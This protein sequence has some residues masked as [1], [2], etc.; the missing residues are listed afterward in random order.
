[1]RKDNGK[2]CLKMFKITLQ[3]NIYTEVLSF[4]DEKLIPICP[5]NQT[6]HQKLIFLGAFFFL[7]YYQLYSHHTHT[8]YIHGNPT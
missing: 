1:M 3:C 6:E 7:F 8:H 2:Q 5:L 4:D